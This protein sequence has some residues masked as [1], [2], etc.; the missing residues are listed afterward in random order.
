M[1]QVR[2]DGLNR[3][4]RDFKRAGGDVDDLKDA[5]APV[6]EKVK[7]A[8]ERTVPVGKT[9]N[10]KSTIR[11]SRAQRSVTIR[12][13]NAKAYYAP[14]VSFGSVHN[15]TPKPFLR[16]ALNQTDVSGEVAVAIDSLLRKSGL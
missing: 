7:K 9:G 13:G 14:F 16:E 6:G 10:L 5:L 3:L 4:V 15:P 1:A 11:V 2:V 12:A 8:A